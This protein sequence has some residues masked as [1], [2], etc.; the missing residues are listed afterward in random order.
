MK[1]KKFIRL[2]GKGETVG[3]VMSRRTPFFE[4]LGSG[5][6]DYGPRQIG[7]RVLTIQKHRLSLLCSAGLTSVM[8]YTVRVPQLTNLQR[9]ERFRDLTYFS[10]ENNLFSFPFSIILILFL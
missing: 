1:G 5:L 4:K 2:N 8:Y 3:V 9:L 6:F 7:G 10:K